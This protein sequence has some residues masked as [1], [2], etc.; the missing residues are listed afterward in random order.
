MDVEL[1]WNNDER[2]IIVQASGL[3]EKTPKSASRSVF[4]RAF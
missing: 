4:F 2:A 3:F 1:L